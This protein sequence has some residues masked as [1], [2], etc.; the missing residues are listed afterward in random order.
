MQSYVHRLALL[1]TLIASLLSGCGPLSADEARAG[2][3]AQQAR[4]VI[5][6]EALPPEARRVIHKILADIPFTHPKD[7]A[8][9]HNRERLLPL[10]PTGYYREY[11]VLTPGTSGRGARRLVTGGIPPKV[12]FYT[13]DH[14]RSFT[15]VEVS[16]P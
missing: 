8:V 12:Y 5:T 2:T 7:G 11:T 9:F 15:R 1:L 6:P 10:K 3:N 13:N 14:Y 16:Q 4:A